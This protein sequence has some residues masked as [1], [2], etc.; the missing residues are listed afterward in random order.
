[1]QR[2]FDV[3]VLTTCALDYLTWHNH[4]PT[5]TETINGVTVQRFPVDTPRDINQFNAFA[6]RLLTREQRTLVEELEWIRRQGP[7]SS[8]LLDAIRTQEDR[9]D[10]F[11][12]V[13]YSYLTTYLGLQLVPAKSLLI[14]AAHEEPHFT[15]TAF[16]PIF[17][18]P[19]GIFYNTPEEKMLVQRTWHNSAVPSC[20]AGAGVEETHLPAPS[21]T[22]RGGR[23]VSS[24]ETPLN[25]PHNPYILYIGRIDIMKGCQELIEF[26]VRVSRHFPDVDLVFIGKP[27]MEIPNHPRIHALGFV[28]E[29]Q[30]AQAI[31]QATVLVNPSEYESLSLVV[32][33]AW[34]HG[35]PVLVN[36]RCDVLAGHCVAGNGGLYYTN[37]DEFSLCLD[38][39]LR[40][41]QL[42]DTLGRQGQQYVSERYSWD[43]VEKTYVDFITH[44]GNT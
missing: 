10:L 2:Y 36:G 39:L 44:I 6:R 41:P 32:L 35:T 25:L 1:M 11:I 28:S 8:G 7:A 33:E 18:L 5:G 29:A 13:T 31:Q 9:I 38:L 43:S 19:R 26:F 37:Y 22:K 23:E 16:Q 34:Q 14:P 40:Q 42:R 21:L 3:S 27:A 24:G 30:K 12:F 4:Y 17:H 20:V 15:F